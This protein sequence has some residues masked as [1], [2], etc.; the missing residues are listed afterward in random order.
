MLAVGGSMPLL[1]TIAFILGFVPGL[2]DW[3]PFALAAAMV[4]L[5][6]FKRINDRYGHAA[7]GSCPPPGRRERP[8]HGHDRRL[9]RERVGFRGTRP[10]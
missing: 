7:G 10:L 9:R 8:G 1:F 6:H 4:D 5:D 3:T 2:V